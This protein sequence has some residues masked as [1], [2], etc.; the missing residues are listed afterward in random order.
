MS[1]RSVRRPY[2]RVSNSNNYLFGKFVI[3]AFRPVGSV[4]WLYPRKPPGTE[5][6]ILTAFPNQAWLLIYVGMV[7]SLS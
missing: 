2:V 3:A 5:E 7:E 6:L 4:P 1:P